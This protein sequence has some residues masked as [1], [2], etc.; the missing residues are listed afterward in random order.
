MM[1]AMTETR[2]GTDFGRTPDPEVVEVTLLWV[3]DVLTARRDVGALLDPAEQA[4][5]ARFR[6]AADRDRFVAGRVALRTLLGRHLGTDPRQIMF[7]LEAAGKPYLAGS[8]VRFNL[9]HSGDLLAVAVTT[10]DVGVDVE[11]H[12]AARPLSALGGRLFAAAEIERMRS[13]GDPVAAFYA[14]WSAREAVL[15]ADGAGLAL[16]SA[17]FAV[18]PPSPSLS[19]IICDAGV[20]RLADIRVA[21]LDMPAGYSGAVALRGAAQR[22][23]QSGPGRAPDPTR[24]RMPA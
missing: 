23:V 17:D 12:K 20:E 22:V 4:R 15:K 21:S 18:P 5:A 11:R 16:A 2:A 1:N 9:A 19:A 10:S 6:R 3:G 13:A 8:P 24:G 7:G 14:T